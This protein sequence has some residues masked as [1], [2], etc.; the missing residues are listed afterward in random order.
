MTSAP[1]TSVSSN[2]K[3]GGNAVDFEDGEESDDPLG[4]DVPW[5]FKS[6]YDDIDNDLNFAIRVIPSEEIISEPVSVKAKVISKYLFGEVLGEGSYGKVKEALNVETLERQA[7]KIMKKRKLRRI[8]HGE[9]NVKRE[10]CM[11]KRLN[12]KNVIKLTDV[13]FNEEKEKLFIVMEFCVC[14]LHEL[15]KA[16]PGNVLPEWQAN[17]YFHQLIDGLEYLHSKGVVHK[18]IKPSNLLLTTDETLKISDFGVAEQLNPFAVD[19]SCTTSQ[20]S[21]AFQPPEIANGLDSFS[22]F[23]LDIWACGISLF[24][25][26]TSK[27]PFE[28]EN[29]Y[30]LFENIGKAILI[31]PPN[32][33]HTLK[34][35]LEG[36]L[37]SNY[38][39][40]FCISEIRDHIWM[41]KLY[42]KYE[43]RVEFPTNEKSDKVRNMST[44]PYLQLFN[45]NIV[46][47]LQDDFIKGHNVSELFDNDYSSNNDFFHNLSASAISSK[48][49][50]NDDKSKNLKSRKYNCK[51]M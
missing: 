44:I 19:D 27:Y 1:D 32:I 41:R 8:P 47:Y 31:I 45:E 51:A 40:R 24:N 20:G 9:E 7:I 23:K 4:D 12:H 35:L 49:I 30:K 10:I 11:L 13:L 37:H 50:D 2:F 38:Q 43:A 48:T 16:A 5:S 21:P 42:Y 39:K 26:V 22:G 14:G 17:F 3:V 29:I 25:M 34:T 15:L 46:S 18:D 6:F 33:S 28:G 36:L